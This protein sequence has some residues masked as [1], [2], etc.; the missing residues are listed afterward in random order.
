[1]SRLTRTE[2][3]GKRAPGRRGRPRKDGCISTN[4]RQ[5]ILAA[6]VRLF[7]SQ[8]CSR[9][10]MSAISHEVGI[11]QSSIYYWFKSKD[12]IILG[13]LDQVAQNNRPLIE[14]LDRVLPRD[15]EEDLFICA[16]AY[17]STYVLC[18]LPFD[19]REVEALALRRP[20][21]VEEH[22]A[23]YERFY[24]AVYA[25]LERGIRK[26]VFRVDSPDLAVEVFFAQ[27]EGAHHR[28]HLRR[29]N[30]W[31]NTFCHVR[32]FS[33][34]GAPTRADEARLA[35]VAICLALGTDRKAQAL[36]RELS[37]RGWLDSQS[38]IELAMYYGKRSFEFG[39][40]SLCRMV[41]PDDLEGLIVLDAGCRRGKGVY[42]LSEKVGPTG[43][44]IGT[45]WNASFI[46]E[47]QAGVP[48]ALER[49][50]LESNNMEFFTAYPEDLHAAGI[51]DASVD[52][53]YGN[54]VLNL[55]FEPQEVLNELFR[56]LK[57]EGLLVLEI[58]VA[59]RERPESLL[60]SAR[61]LGNC[62]QAAFSREQLWKMLER[63]GFAEPEVVESLPVRPDQGSREDFKV[64]LAVEN[65]K[66]SYCAQ[67]LHLHKAR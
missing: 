8:G 7:S 13:L 62:V 57:P 40:E 65:D 16:L 53:A 60:R 58:I 19:F 36:F 45:D 54:A 28:H 32:S 38:H 18:D 22:L 2:H 67:V 25:A 11:D 43:R 23:G 12:D 9:T 61:R 15:G 14:R 24:R 20:K 5:E 31:E 3:E 1:M 44:V 51:E 50:G 34:D 66:T 48:R 46:R 29:L 6:A 4:Q 63:A 26:G 52:V 55:T 10:S 64:P 33:F 42:K 56:V 27:M 49:S 39:R 21:D 35:A 30:A 59:D 17:T 37:L 47:A 41:L